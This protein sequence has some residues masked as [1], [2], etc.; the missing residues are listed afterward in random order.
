VHTLRTQKQPA[1][2]RPHLNFDGFLQQLRFRV[3]AMLSM[4]RLGSFAAVSRSYFFN[5][6]NAVVANFIS[7]LFGEFGEP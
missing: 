4:L 6:C 2:R 3:D 7:R 5:D 1:I